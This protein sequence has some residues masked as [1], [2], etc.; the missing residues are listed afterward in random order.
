MSTGCGRQARLAPRRK[1]LGCHIPSTPGDTESPCNP[2]NSCGDHISS[3]GA[4]AGMRTHRLSGAASGARAA[5]QSQLGARPCLKS[6]ARGSVPF[7]V[8]FPVTTYVLCPV[9]LYSVHSGPSRREA[10]GVTFSR[11][12]GWRKRG[13]WLINFGGHRERVRSCQEQR[14]GVRG[15][16]L[17]PRLQRLP[18]TPGTGVPGWDLASR[19][20]GR[21]EG[22]G[23]MSPPPWHSEGWEAGPRMQAYLDQGSSGEQQGPATLECNTGLQGV[24][25]LRTEPP[26]SDE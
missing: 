3:T 6:L 5:S 26:D 23:G 19:R 8:L 25:G 4:G 10:T 13:R 18:A 24:L 9:R 15:M 14:R 7:R 21:N 11:A 2:P 22:G 17:P 12:T 20:Q 16:L 1:L